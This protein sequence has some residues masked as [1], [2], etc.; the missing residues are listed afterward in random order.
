[1][2]RTP[3]EKELDIWA[4]GLERGERMVQFFEKEIASLKKFTV[5]D[6]GC[7]PGGVALSYR[8]KSAEV[9]GIDTSETFI[10]LAKIRQHERKLTRT[11]FLRSNAS[12]L[13][14]KARTFDLVILN[15]VL[16]W[17]PEISANEVVE[18][19]SSEDCQQSP[20]DL[21][22]QTLKEIR[23]VLKLGG[24]L[25]LAIENRW[26]P[27]NLVKDPHSYIPLVA[28]LPRKVSNWVSLVLSGRPYRHYIYSYWG[29][30]RLLLVAGFSR[31]KVYTP[32]SKYQFPLSIVDPEQREELLKAVR[33][34]PTNTSEMDQFT[35]EAV[36]Y[37]PRLKKVLFY[38]IAVLG[39]QKLF[40]RGFVVITVTK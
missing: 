22:L 15:G 35:I 34:I 6:V 31:S 14:F 8:Q 24:Y 17:V 23:R 29:L 40:P 18:W 19:I 20:Y 28:F 12:L 26:F 3:T 1:M 27:F 25:Y 11:H 30:K 37:L 36:G 38:L 4:Y 33:K 32:I 21:Q 7:G 10:A 13:P 5:L 9:I 16:E 39:L 2:N